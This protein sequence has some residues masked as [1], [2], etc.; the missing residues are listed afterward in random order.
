MQLLRE[1]DLGRRPE[2][3]FQVG[4]GPKAAVSIPHM[5]S[6]GPTGVSEPP[7][8]RRCPRDSVWCQRL[9]IFWKLLWVGSDH[10]IVGGDPSPQ[11][12]FERLKGWGLGALL[13]RVGQVRSLGGSQIEPILEE[14]ENFLE[15]E[16]LGGRVMLG[17]GL[18]PCGEEGCVHETCN[19][20]DSPR[21]F[22]SRTCQSSRR[23]C[24]WVH[25]YPGSCQ[26][27]QGAHAWRGALAQVCR[28]RVQGQLHGHAACSCPGPA[29]QFNAV[30]VLTFLITVDQKIPFPFSFRAGPRQ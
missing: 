26:G 5:G 12:P 29:T 25:T 20:G 17:D 19:G 27:E 30:A 21:A 23:C 15:A 1:T 28:P 6:R 22:V 4:L 9:G 8:S 24:L 2:S 16:D 14:E 10:T 13:S 7:L 11:Q 3:P 18:A